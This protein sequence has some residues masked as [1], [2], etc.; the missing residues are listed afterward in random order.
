MTKGAMPMIT[1]ERGLTLAEILVAAAVIMT[2]L[3]AVASAYPYAMSGVE[4][5]RQQSTATFLAEQKIEEL[6]GDAVN[7]PELTSADLVPGTTTENSVDGYANYA[8]VTTVTN[9]ATAT[10]RLVQV[11]VSY[12]PSVSVA[13]TNPI[14]SVSV[15]TVL[16]TRQ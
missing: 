6:K 7:D 11:T 9:G 4:A 5:G 13:S 2:G 14:R 8:R 15:A 16:A 3:I 12:R 10:T 1:N